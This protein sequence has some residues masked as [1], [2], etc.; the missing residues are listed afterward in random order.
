MSRQL[1]PVNQKLKGIARYE[2]Y[3]MALIGNITTNYD[4][5]AQRSGFAGLSRRYSPSERPL[6]D[7]D[8]RGHNTEK[9]TSSGSDSSTVDDH[10]SRDRQEEGRI[11]DLA[12]QFTRQSTRSFQETGDFDPDDILRPE[13]GT[14]YDPFSESFNSREWIKSLLAIT[15]R[16]PEKYPRRT[17]GI[18][19]K[20]LSV[21][22]FASDVEYQ[23]TVGNVILSGLGFMWDIIA[24]RQRKVEIIKRFDGIVEAGEML[25]VLGPPGSGCSTFLKTITG[26]T[27]G[28]FVGEDTYINYQGITPK[29]MHSNFRGEAIYAA[30]QEVHFP[31]LTVGDTLNFAAEARAPREPPGGMKKREFAKILARVVMSTLGISHTINTK[32]GSEYVRGVSGG[33]RKRVSIAE[34]MLA[35][36]PLQAWDNSTRGLDAANAIEFCKHLRGTTNILGNTACVAIYQSPQAAYDYFDKVVLIYQGEQ[37]YFGSTKKAKDFFVR[38]GFECPE[39]QT[40]PDFLTSLTSP[41]ERIVRTGFENKV[42]RTPAEFA[43]AWRASE[44]YAQ[45]QLQLERYDERFPIGGKSLEA[46]Q[47]SRRA[48]QSKRLSPKSPYTLSYKAQIALCLRRGFWRLKAD[49]SLTL[50]QL[51]ANSTMALIVSS[52]FYNLPDDTSS[53]YSRGSLLFFAILLN[54]FGS[55][56]EILTLYA[57]RPIVEKHVR[58]AFYHASAEAFASMLTDMPYKIINSICFNIILYFM[59]NLRRTPGAFFFFYLIS[60]C[61]TLTMSM[62]FRSI[63]SLSRTLTQALAPAALAILGLVIYTG[64]ALPITYMR[65]WSRWINYIDPIAYGFESLMINEFH[66][67]NFPCGTYVP[68]YGTGLEASCNT[69]G[70]VPGQD[71]VDGDAYINS[72]YRY[73]HAHKWRNFGILI[74][75]MLFFMCT[76][77]G[78]TELISSKKSKGEVLVFPRNAMPKR[79]RPANDEEDGRSQTGIISEKPAQQESKEVAGILRQTA[80]FHWENVIYDIKIKK[81][82]RRILDHVS[83]WVKPGTLTCLMGVSGAGKTT[84]LDV[85]ASRVTMG[86]I[87]G[88]ML[89]DGRPRDDSFQRKTGYVQQQDLHLSTSTVR[90]ALRFSALLRQPA[91]VPRQEKLDYVE[92]VL[93]LLEMDT[94]SN[95][96]VGV[97]GEGLNVEQR[98]RLTIGVELVAKPELLLFLD[99]PTS[100]LDSQTSW[101]IVQLLQKLA[102]H[103]QAILCTVHQPS[104]QLFSQFNRLLLL[105]AGGKQIYFGEVGRNAETLISYLERN[106]ARPC[107]KNENPAEYMLSATGAAPGSTTD[108][109]WHQTWLQSPEN[110][111][112]RAELDRMKRELPNKASKV[113]KTGDNTSHQEFAATV[114]EQTREVLRRVFQQW[115]RTPSY[116]WSKFILCAGSSL[117]IGFSFFNSGTS[118]QALQNQ[119]FSVFMLFAVFGQL[120]QQMM[121]HFILQ[122]DLYEVRERPAKIYSWKVFMLSNIIVELPWN[123]LMAIVIY[124]CW[125]YPLGYYKNAGDDVHIRGFL[126]FLLT[127]TFLL[128]AST[129]THMIISFNTTAENGGSISNLLFSM[130]LIFCGVLATKEA[131][132]GVGNAQVVC[133]A[134]EYLH[135]QPPPGQTCQS[136]ITP[137][138]RVA[139]GYMQNP[140]ATTDCSF[141]PVSS[142]NPK[143]PQRMRKHKATKTKKA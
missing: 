70:S 116:I 98:K 104:A 110:E 75:F 117:F 125:Y 80:I 20:H 35:G 47:I 97:L 40:V 57:Q 142:T 139:G 118:V 37:C 42:P 128:F 137:Y 66:G 73:Y 31:R 14:I 1:S 100:G 8:R 46:F 84:L 122:R 134:N 65:G 93:N 44:E 29:Q 3:S 131:M 94:Y 52:V 114:W 124:F 121:P 67:R 88:E 123:S 50:F 86:V 43:A 76:Y 132:P 105:A 55:A 143:N 109:N 48:Q 96:V 83:G 135:F 27:H 62:F 77:L 12:R 51:F 45:L 90:E 63:A 136:W 138:E 111:D 23:P 6:L 41:S 33:E 141:C 10:S 24:R 49:P 58:F 34:A 72:A 60:F 39:R 119:L 32:V 17:A 53:F 82:E 120:G 28:I 36:A 113:D 103:G 4:A 87:D 11:V 81:E 56:L 21:H 133:A 61:L 30:E 69:V 107:G 102:N 101:S 74:G 18:A 54:A 78:A 16:D 15:S 64:F 59:A 106:G 140:D 91:K 95:A 13:R 129:F 85:L 25:V 19:F 26:E 5:S 9:H 126:M 38:M 79:G 115:W 130:C 71:F 7:N 127:W 68:P 99:E 108:V 2:R 89:V 112:V 22:G 92:E